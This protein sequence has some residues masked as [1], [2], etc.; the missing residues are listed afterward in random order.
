MVH[1]DD[2][3]LVLPP[4][5]APKQI[6]IIPI[7]TDEEVMNK[8][9]EIQNK[10][11]EKY[12]VYIDKTEKSPGFKFA[13]AEVNGIP[14]RIELGKRD[15]EQNTIT[16]ARRDTSEKITISLDTNIEEIVAKTLDD[17]QN[18]LY[19]KAKERM[20]QKTYTA[21]NLDDMKNIIE[22][23]PGFI[24]AMWCGEE[25]CEDKIKEING[26]KSRCIPF[27]ENQEHID[28]KCVCCGKKAK[29]HVIWG[30]QY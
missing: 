6:V 21:K 20:E 14:L 17:I 5:I 2:K 10:L 25:V 3:G 1:S 8:A 27:K 22:N 9:N 16:I 26:I 4:K 7:G 29:H 13:E 15:L 12:S 19:N 18:N 28:D 11:Q 24:K 30:I 23:H